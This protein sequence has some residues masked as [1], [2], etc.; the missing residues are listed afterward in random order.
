MCIFIRI[1]RCR[2]NVHDSDD[3]QS[4]KQAEKKALHSENIQI[5]IILDVSIIIWRIGIT[6]WVLN[7]LIFVK[8]SNLIKFFLPEAQN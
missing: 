4:K 8:T 1:A 7:E 2:L 6:R 3:S 5:K